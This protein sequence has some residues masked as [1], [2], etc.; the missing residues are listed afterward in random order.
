[1]KITHIGLKQICFLGLVFAGAS[2]S[3]VSAE[4]VTEVLPIHKTPT[5]KLFWDITNFAVLIFLFNKYL[6]PMLNTAVEEGI[7]EIEVGLGEEER[8]KQ[9]LKSQIEE[10]KSQLDGIVSHKKSELAQADLDGV[11]IKKEIL[12]HA[13]QLEM[14]TIDK[15]EVDALGYFNNSIQI[16]KNAFTKKVFSGAKNQ[17]KQ[18]EQQASLS[19]YST[20]LINGL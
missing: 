19:T 2:L 13:R 6:T 17:I 9:A 15:V 3:T 11:K 4:A 8:Q 10:L 12:D 18:N 20:G 1:M 14:K 7:E 16:V 5:W